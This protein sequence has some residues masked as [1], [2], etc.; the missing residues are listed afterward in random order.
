MNEEII[1]KKAISGW[2]WKFL[3]RM[4][5][6]GISL[7]ISI[8]LARLLSP[9][10][11]GVVS[12]VTIFFTFSNVLISGGLNT[13]LIQKKDADLL[14][15]S[16]VFSISLGLSLI[17]YMLL[18]IFAPFISR[19]YHADI[20]VQIIRVM[21]ISLP[22]Y[23]IKSVYCAFISVNLQFKSFF[24]ATI[25]GTVISAFIGIGMALSGYGVWALVA[26]QLSNTIID[27]MI[28]VF[29][30]RIKLS[31]KISWKRAKTLFGY[32]SKILM[33]NL[34]GTAYTEI[35]PLF[36]GIKYSSAELSF[37]TKGKLFPGAISATIT[38][39]LSA[40]LFPVLSKKQNEKQSLLHYTR[41]Y[42]KVSSFLVFPAMLGFFSISDNFISVVLTNRWMEASYYMKI[43]CLA[44]MFDIVAVGNCETIKAMGRSDIYLKIELIKKV[45]YFITL[46]V[47]IALAKSP[48][49]LAISALICTLIQVT[50]NSIPNKVLINYRLKEQIEDIIP[51]LLLASIMCIIVMLV[52]KLAINKVLLLFLQISIGFIIYIILNII[53]QNLSYKIVLRLAKDYLGGK[54]D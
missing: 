16:T 44:T 19:I 42:M 6:Q 23:A 10:D 26:Q 37:Y 13:A 17:L 8:I 41:L 47:F 53:T 36:I 9:T 33:S 30:T 35:N 49:Q 31:L 34:I 12:V 21:G 28:L 27:T 38:N 15:Y 48:K 29:V 24:F 25:G 11:Y 4:I 52:G 3:E 18:Y 20:L 2:I 50:I 54:N 32:G 1:K 45:G 46:G 22:I 51:N 5:A 14:D 40:V 39:T 43:F 7:I